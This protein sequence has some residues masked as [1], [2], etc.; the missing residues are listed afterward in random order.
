VKTE[1]LL[2]VTTTVAAYRHGRLRPLGLP[3][4]HQTASTGTQT[5]S[6]KITVWVDAPIPAAGTSRRPTPRFQISIVQI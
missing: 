3:V 4:V 2:S 1:K 5:D 6:V